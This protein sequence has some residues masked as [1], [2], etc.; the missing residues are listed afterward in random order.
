MVKTTAT[1]RQFI[2]GLILLLL[3]SCGIKSYRTFGQENEETDV[4]SDQY[5]DC[6]FSQVIYDNS[7]DANVYIDFKAK[8]E[9]EVEITSISGQLNWLQN[10]KQIDCPQILT[11]TTVRLFQNDQSIADSTFW[12]NQLIT[13]RFKTISGTGNSLLYVLEFSD[14]TFKFVPETVDQMTV[15]LIIHTKSKATGKLDEHKKT[16]KL[17]ADKHHYFWFLRDG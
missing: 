9:N 11:S 5:I 1:H 8:T 15:E 2:G 13:D 17:N 7:P 14:T 10:D 6:K 16:I 3:S 4:F 12:T